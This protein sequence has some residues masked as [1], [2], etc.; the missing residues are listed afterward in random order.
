MEKD[1]SDLRLQATKNSSPCVGGWGATCVLPK[2][3]S[4]CSQE[5]ELLT[6]LIF[7]SEP[8]IPSV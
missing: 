4:T 2:D 8:S 3:T 1:L 7:S 5:E 6:W